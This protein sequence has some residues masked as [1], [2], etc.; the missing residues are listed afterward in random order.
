MKK[1]K[2]L[3]TIRVKTEKLLARDKGL[4]KTLKTKLWFKS[5][6]ALLNTSGKFNGCI[7]YMKSTGA[8]MA[9]NEQTNHNLNL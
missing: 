6:S 4:R 5:H 7:K 8:S 9:Q 1:R 2:G 3:L